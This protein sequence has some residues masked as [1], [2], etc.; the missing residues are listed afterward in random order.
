MKLEFHPLTV[1][2]VAPLTDDAVAISLDVPP[3]LE[4]TFRYRPGQHMVFRAIIDGEDVRRSYSFCSNANQGKLRIGVKRLEGGTFSTYATTSL[5][6]GDT[7]EAMPPIGSFTIDPEPTSVRHRCAIVAGSGITP[8][9]SLISTTLEAEPNSRWTVVFGNSRATTVMFLDEIEGL[10]DRYGPRLHLIH[11]LSREETVP[12]L[13]GRIDDEKLTQLFST[14]IDFSS[15]DEW[16]LCGPYEMVTGARSYIERHGTDP[17]LVHDELFFAGPPDPDMVRASA[18][19][20][21]VE[22]VFTLD[23]RESTVKMEP[24]ETILDAA[25][26]VRPELPF[27]CRGG[28]C[29]T[30]KAHIVEGDVEMAKN[31][32]LV[33]EDLAQGF[34]LTCQAHPRSDRVV[35]D[36]DHR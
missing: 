3:E 18:E 36:F 29:A 20:G 23:G 9:L 2:E 6:A 16:F 33:A 21:S 5:R 13:T 19:T 1:T 17:T 12:V 10:K 14:L 34:A 24:S 15:I 27:S 22:M 26:S 4:Q 32:S 31:Y 7:L 8:A 11:V 28:M 35:V 30:C 25:L